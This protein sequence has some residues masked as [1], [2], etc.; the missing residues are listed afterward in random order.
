MRMRSLWMISRARWS[1]KDVTGSVTATKRGDM[2]LVPSWLVRWTW[3][4]RFPG[5]VWS[6]TF[7]PSSFGVDARIA[8]QQHAIE[9]RQCTWM[10]TPRL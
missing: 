7:S 5:V 1:S 9:A 8:A 10:L 6:E 3:T 2:G 4:R